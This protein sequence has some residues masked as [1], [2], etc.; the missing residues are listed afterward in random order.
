MTRIGMHGGVVFLA[1]LAVGPTALLAGET[2][3][4]TPPPISDI[5]LGNGGVLAG[6]VV[7]PQGVPSVKSRVSL[8]DV[9]NREIAATVTDPQGYFSF[10][11]VR[12]GVYQIVTPQGR[13]VYRLWPA[14]M[15]PPGAQRGALIVNGGDM[16]RGA[17]PPGGGMKFWLTNPIVVGGAVATAIAVPVA[18][19]NS[20]RSPASP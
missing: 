19:H 1:L 6:Q 2:A 7:D 14:G 15:A 12:G 9:Q 20:N 5:A 8:Q 3:P 11:G 4:T 18:I 17:P 16:V 13:G 10:A